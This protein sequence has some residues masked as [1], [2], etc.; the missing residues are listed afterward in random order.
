LSTR[1]GQ[2]VALERQLKQAIRDAVNRPSRKPFAWGGLA[3]YRQLAAIADGIRQLVDQT[4]ETDGL[5]Q[6]LAQIERALNNYRPL[7]NDLAAAHEW[8]RRIAAVLHYRRPREELPAEALTSAAVG[9]AIQQLLALFQPD[10]RRQPAQLALRNALVR[11]WEDFGAE[12]LHCYD[13]VGLPPDNLALEAFFS[14]LRRHQRRISGHKSTRELRTLGHYQVLFQAESEEQLLAQLRTVPLASYREQ[15]RRLHQ[16]SEPQRFV[17]RLHHNPA[18][19]IQCLVD[20]Y[21]ARRRHLRQNENTL[22]AQ[23]EYTN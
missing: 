15:R 16:A 2:L 18:A 1:D 3:G 11:T 4:P 19:T 20:S 13:I 7:A 17:N 22:T 21:T 10:C 12:L 8:L 14:C 23:S 6:T 5:R 9:Q